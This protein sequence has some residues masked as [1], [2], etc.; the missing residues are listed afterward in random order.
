MHANLSR[1][2]LPALENRVPRSPTIPVG[3]QH[4]LHAGGPGR[5][6]LL[7][8]QLHLEL[9]QGPLIGDPEQGILRDAGE[10]GGDKLVPGFPGLGEGVVGRSGPGILLSSQ[11]GLQKKNLKAVVCGVIYRGSGWAVGVFVSPFV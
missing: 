11:E 7:P 1:G 3:A 6:D 4:A 5:R 2:D 9:R 10:R 8:R